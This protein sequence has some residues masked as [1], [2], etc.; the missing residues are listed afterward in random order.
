M[1]DLPTTSSPLSR[2]LPPRRH[3]RR[4]HILM[5]L[6]VFL[7][8]A[9]CGAA[10]A[11]VMIARS[12]HH[13]IHHPEEAA[14]HISARLSQRLNL[15]DEQS[16]QVRQIISRRQDALMDI[17]RDIQPR[18]EVELSALEEEIAG[19]LSDEQ[20]EKWHALADD[21]RGHWL[22]PGPAHSHEK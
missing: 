13:V 2:I 12:I 4:R 11:S 15:T 7:G 17:R 3:S 16:E 19:V 14:A 20:R 1:S 21:F 5:A 8:G 6:V 10:V 22:L 9:A 18:I